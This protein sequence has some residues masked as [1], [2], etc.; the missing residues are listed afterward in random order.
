MYVH[1]DLIEACGL[2]EDI[3]GKD[4]YNLNQKMKNAVE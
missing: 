2:W 3:R 4:I 1:I